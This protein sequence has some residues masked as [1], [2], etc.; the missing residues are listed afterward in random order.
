[1]SGVMCR[2]LFPCSMKDSTVPHMGPCRLGTRMAVEVI[3]I[4]E[5]EDAIE[6]D[7]EGRSYLAV[8]RGTDS[9]LPAVKSGII[10]TT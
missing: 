6:L 5:R 3:G 2:S 7:A 9:A 8:L 10:P 1:M 4:E